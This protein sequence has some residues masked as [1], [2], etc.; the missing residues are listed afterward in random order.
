MLQVELEKLRLVL[1][2][3]VDA[4]ESYWEALLDD[5]WRIWRCC[6]PLT[7]ICSRKALRQTRCPLTRICSRGTL[8]QMT[9]ARRGSRGNLLFFCCWLPFSTS[10]CRHRSGRYC[11]FAASGERQR[12]IWV[13]F[14]G[15]LARTAGAFSTGVSFML[16][17]ARWT[18]FSAN[19]N[20]MLALCPLT[21]I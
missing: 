14:L 3:L 6:R 8:R 10:R 7:R 18:G 1:E 19:K 16:A 9:A 15:G 5:S 20:V 12:T 2:P 17:P 4:T 21:R 13:T 11:F